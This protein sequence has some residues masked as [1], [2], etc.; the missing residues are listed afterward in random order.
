MKKIKLT[1]AQL[2]EI[3]SQVISEQS[4]GGIIKEGDVPC[5]IWCK[6]KYA[7]IGSRGDVVKMIQ[8]LLAKGCGDYGPYNQDNMGGGM[9]EGCVENWTNCD[10]KFGDETKKA[11]QHLQENLRLEMDGAVGFDTL[12]ALCGICYGSGSYKESAEYILCNDKCD[13]ETDNQGNDGIQDVIDN[14]DCDGEC[15]FDEWC[16]NPSGN[17]DGDHWNDCE[18]IKACLYYASRKDGENWHY[19]LQCMQGRF[20]YN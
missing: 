18:R 11:V 5:D 13:C 15:D 9:N 10:G 4:Y 7:K 20:G 14:I 6:R 12:T 19:F 17:C 8:H 2:T 3:I 16:D 1:E